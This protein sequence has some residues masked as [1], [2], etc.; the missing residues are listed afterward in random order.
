MHIPKILSLRF[1]KD[2]I[3]KENLNSYLSANLQGMN[4]R[5]IDIFVRLGVYSVLVLI[6]SKIFMYDAS[7]S[8]HEGQKFTEYS[9]TELSQEII[10]LIASVF[11]FI[12]AYKFEDSRPISILFGGFTMVAFCREFDFLTDSINSSFWGVTSGI[13]ILTVFAISWKYWK[14]LTKSYYEYYD[15]KAFAYMISGV[16]VTFLFSR[17]F[18]KGDFWKTI[19]EDHY[20]R[21]VKN[22]GEECV[23][24]MGDILILIS[25]VEYLI[26]K[27]QQK[28]KLKVS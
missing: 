23:E 1:I 14:N 6:A 11:F 2:L 12:A 18:G 22:A 20:I 21:S 9:L 26:F 16:L 19:M 10:F 25:S 4:N 24:V 13:V 15:S 7:G 8:L 3:R 5:Y 27:I 28:R 17:L